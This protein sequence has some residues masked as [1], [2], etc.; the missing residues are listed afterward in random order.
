M[1]NYN[2][3]LNFDP[4]N[5]DGIIMFCLYI[6]IIMFMYNR[7]AIGIIF[8]LISFYLYF[9]SK[10]LENSEKEVCRKS[11]I[12]NPYANTL[13]DN[14]ESRLNGCKVDDNTINNNFNHNLYR[15]ET[16]L[17]DKRSM[18][19]NYYQVEDTYPNN[20]SKFLE[21]FKSDKRCKSDNINCMYPSFFLN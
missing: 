1:I 13:W 4:T 10:D 17:F 9:M 12:D 20:I 5:K 21:I 14:K 11:T 2:K 19:M 15:N 6:G 8:W 3:L 16:D 18:Q 7:I